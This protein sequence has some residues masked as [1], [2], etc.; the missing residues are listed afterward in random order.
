MVLILVCSLGLLA[1]NQYVEPARRQQRLIAEVERLG[2]S[3]RT[4]A[5]D[6]SWTEIVF[7]EGYFL[8]IRHLWLPE[9]ARIDDAWLKH[10]QDT[11]R[12]SSLV[13]SN[14]PISDAGLAHLSGL[15]ELE[16]LVLSNT[17]VTD[18][19]LMHLSSLTRLKELSLRG[20]RVADH[21][22]ASLNT[23][24]ELK[25]LDFAGT[26]VGDAGIARLTSLEKLE[27]LD[28]EYTNVTQA[29]V[30]HLKRLPALGRVAIEGTAILP[31]ALWPELST[32]ESLKLNRAL[33]DMTLAEFNDSPLCDVAEYFGDYHK[34][35][36]VLDRPALRAAGID[37]ATPIT[38]NLKC[39]LDVALEQVLKPLGLKYVPWHEVLLITPEKPNQ[40]P[41]PR[42][43]IGPGEVLS[44][45]LAAALQKGIYLELVEVPLAV[46]FC[47]L[48]PRP[49]FDSHGLKFVIDENEIDAW[50][51]H[52]SGSFGNMS[53][54]T[55]LESLFHHLNLHGVIKDNVIYVH[56]GPF[57]LDFPQP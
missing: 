42:L 10:L 34:V 22:L 8:E 26:A 19:G 44:K 14:T 37:R 46:L 21:G 35:A 6:T 32:R 12:L 28:L 38:K 11:P 48:S 20:C 27:L 52:F 7:G 55:A 47:D 9:T 56:P 2:G 3:V 41:L 5:Y 39:R 1:W 15:N 16:I 24:T 4:E 23:L 43:V 49:I 17:Q 18:A 51:A 33:A 36:V 40:T 53:A 54:A 31:T 50:Q 13:L 57:P 30:R 25:Q 29:S 45:E